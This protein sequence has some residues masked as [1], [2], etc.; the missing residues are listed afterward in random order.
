MGRPFELTIYAGG[1]EIRH[2][3]SEDEIRRARHPAIRAAVGDGSREELRRAGAM[4]AERILNRDGHPV[5][6]DDVNNAFWVVPEAAI[7]AVQ[8]SDPEVT[9]RDSARP[10]GFA[11]ERLGNGD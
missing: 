9:S 6:V 2:E 11:S 4:L 7:A 1:Q 10:F 3:L 5:V 8:F